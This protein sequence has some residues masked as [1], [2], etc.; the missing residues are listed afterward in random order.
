MS[1]EVSSLLLDAPARGEGEPAA[2]M[3]GAV[4]SRPR[5]VT[6]SA[7]LRL[8]A[9]ASVFKKCGALE[10]MKPRISHA[11][12]MVGTCVIQSIFTATE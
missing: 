8:G 3:D 10:R 11:Q 6:F 1:A 5:G 9:D 2:A 7:L 12:N 4:C